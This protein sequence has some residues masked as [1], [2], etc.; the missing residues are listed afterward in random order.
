[1]ENQTYKLGFLCIIGIAHLPETLEELKKKFEEELLEQK[2]TK[3]E[4]DFKNEVLTKVVDSALVD[5]P[6]VLVDEE[7]QTMIE[8][9]R[10]RLSQQGFTLEQYFQI[11]GQSLD[12][13]SAQMRVDALGKV[14]VR[15]VLDALAN[16]EKIEVKAED[17]EEEYATIAKNY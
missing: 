15:L 16:A 7:T 13:L 11:T 2:T 14:K 9:F 4:E 6:D 10:N 1:M 12:E 3:A 5:I 8:D 17:V